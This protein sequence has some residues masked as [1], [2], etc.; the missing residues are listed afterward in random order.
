MLDKSTKRRTKQNALKLITHKAKQIRRKN[1]P[2]KQAISRA[3]K[4]LKSKK[5]TL[6][7]VAK[8]KKFKYPV[9]LEGTKGQFKPGIIP[10]IKISYV[11]GRRILGKVTSPD[12]VVSTIRKLFKK[13][14]IEGWEHFF[15]LYLNNQN[16]IIGYNL[17]SKG[18]LTGTLVDA[19]I[20]FSIALKSLATG[21]IL[22][23]NHPSGSTKPS[24]GDIQQTQKIKRIGEFHE[25][26]I[27]D[28]IIITKDNYYSFSEE[29]IL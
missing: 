16:Q 12:Q 4:L 17:H 28:H 14:A 10:E 23:H 25:I 21:I 5:S 27:L 11:R 20:I 29:G 18:G 13:G 8:K 3:S 1:E 24:N 2:W 6:K 19:R 9:S 22:S 15:V 26:K 7:G